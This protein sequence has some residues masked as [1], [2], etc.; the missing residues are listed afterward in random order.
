MRFDLVSDFVT[1]SVEATD[2]A[3]PSTYKIK[4]QSPLISRVRVFRGERIVPMPELV[5]VSDRMSLEM[6][7]VVLV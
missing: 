4:R 3:G 6:N 7:D 2:C 5:T 1:G